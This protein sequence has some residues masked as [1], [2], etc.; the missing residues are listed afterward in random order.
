MAINIIKKWYK[1]LELPSEWEDV[2]FQ[3]AKEFSEEKT[4][5]KIEEN[6]DPY[7]WLFTQEDKLLAL[8]YVLYKCENF[9]QKG[10]EKGIDESILIKTLSEV[11]RYAK[12]YNETTE[13]HPIGVYTI[14][15]LGKIL[16]GN[17]YR[18]GRLE[19]EMRDAL[20]SDEELGLT[21]GQNVIG[22]HIP[23]NGGPFTPEA[24]D[25]AYKIAE[26]FFAKHFP[27]FEYNHYVCSSWLLDETLRDFL[28]PESNIIKFMDTFK[29]IARKE[30][31]SALTYLFARGVGI[32]HLPNITP[33]TSLQKA[34]VNHLQNGGKLY[35]GYGVRYA[36]N[37]S[38]MV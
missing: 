25:E 33:K 24:C 3:K 12:E 8:V 16:K 28:K 22:V 34:I 21:E 35:S 9:F 37:S 20:H 30:A 7:E 4:Y 31:Y 36:K 15:W 32:E 6:N 2:V 38:K 17:I 27:E 29:I 19:F 14:K 11:K 13:N 18:L 23:D 10:R 26:G 1:T 5:E